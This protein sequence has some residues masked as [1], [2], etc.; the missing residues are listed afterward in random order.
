M[1]AASSPPLGPLRAAT[2]GER[3]AHRLSTAIALGE[4]SVGD[5]LPTERDL[6]GSLEVSRESVRAALRRLAETGLIEIRRGRG[7][8]AFVLAQWAEASEDAVREALLTR[9]DDFEALFDYRRLVESLIARTA[10]A[11]ATAEDHAAIRTALAEFDAATS[12]GEARGFDTG[13]HL[14]VARAAR[15]P[16]LVRLHRRLLSEVSLGV[17]A[18]PYTW[19][20]YDEAAPQHHGLAAA[21]IAGDE[22]AAA[23]IAGS[24]FAITENALRRLADRVAPGRSSGAIAPGA[25]T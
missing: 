9:W 7:G 21:V 10:A 16:R 22:E 15:N 20:I 3:I 24:H 23:R 12:L 25:G 18:E 19:E 6:A 8:G 1:S 4:F 5:R 17:S 11:R 14:A 13:L 2:T